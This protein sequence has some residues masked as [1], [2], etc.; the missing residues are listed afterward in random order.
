MASWQCGPSCATWGGLAAW[1]DSKHDGDST[2]TPL[3]S[4]V[5]PSHHVKCGAGMMAS[6]WWSRVESPSARPRHTGMVRSPH[7]ASPEG[8]VSISAIPLAQ[9]WPRTAPASP[10]MSAHHGKPTAGV[11]GPCHWHARVE[12]PSALKATSPRLPPSHSGRSCQGDPC[13]CPLCAWQRHCS[14][15]SV[16]ARIHSGLD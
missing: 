10:R 13:R 8:P 4:T 15:G 7:R 6:C 14:H 1:R 16:T 3:Y 9:T 12:R 11:A 5:M 2:T